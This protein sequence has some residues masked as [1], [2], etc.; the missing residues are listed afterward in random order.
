MN[1]A[2]LNKD[3]VIKWIYNYWTNIEFLNDCRP[4][5]FYN[6]STTIVI[7]WYTIIVPIYMYWI[8]TDKLNRNNLDFECKFWTGKVLN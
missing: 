1:I 3:K 4:I 5:L 6:N 7:I 2:L 8:K